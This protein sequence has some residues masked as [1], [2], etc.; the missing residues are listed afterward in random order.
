MACWL[1]PAW[2]A[3][4]RVNALAT[5]RLGGVSRPPYDSLNLGDHVDDD[6]VRVAQNRERLQAEV[7]AGVKLSWL[8]QVH[9]TRVV[10]AAAITPDEPPT[11]DAA[12]TGCAD[13][14]C[15]VMT[16]DCLPVLFCDRAGTRVAAAHAGWR[17]LADGVLEQ[18]L[19]ALA[20]DPSEVLCWLGP[21]IGP[22]AFEVGEE[23]RERFVAEL[24]ASGSAFVAQPGTGNKWL[25]D[26]YQLARLRLQRAGVTAV[27][28][29]DC[30]TFSDT[31]RFFSY[32][33]DGVTGRMATLIWLAAATD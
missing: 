18:T 31:E 16:A 4:A 24:P 13:T 27:Y 15:V 5:T 12:W 14:A 20:G 32:R 2:P 25:A 22:A 19:A 23:V 21:A 9:G 17:G 6:P 29:G 1:A 26:L 8:Q 10:D 3:P 28:G 11:A 7:G 33:R 30:C